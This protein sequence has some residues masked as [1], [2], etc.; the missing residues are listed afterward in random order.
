MKITPEEIRAFLSDLH[1]FHSMMDRDVLFTAEK[2]KIRICRKGEVITQIGTPANRIYLIK[3]G[4]ITLSRLGAN[5]EKV[6][7]GKLDS[8]EF[9]GLETW[10]INQQTQTEAVASSDTTLLYLMVDDLDLAA[11]RSP[12]LQS[13]LNMMLQS[14]NALVEMRLS[15]R[16]EDE[17]VFWTSRKHPIFLWVKL[18]IPVIIGA[19]VISAYFYLLLNAIG[20]LLLL[21]IA[22]GIALFVILLLCV[23]IFIDWGDDFFLITDRRVISRNRVLLLYENKQETPM[24]AI[25]SVGKKIDN[26]IGARIGYG[27]V[28]VRTFTG[29]LVLEKI[30]H[31]DQVA[32]FLE[33]IRSRKAVAHYELERKEKLLEMRRR[34]GMIDEN[35]SSDQ[36]NNPP[37]PPEPEPELNVGETIGYLFNQLFSLRIATARQIVYRKHWFILMRRTFIPGAIFTGVIAYWTILAVRQGILYQ[38]GYPPFVNFLVLLTT[39]FSIS[40]WTYEYFDWRNDRFIVDGRQIVD[41]DQKP[42]GKEHRRAAPLNAIQSVEYKRLGLIGIILNFGTVYIRVGDTEFTFD[43][44]ANPAMIQQEI[45]EFLTSAKEQERQRE[46]RRERERVLDWIEIYHTVV[47]GRDEQDGEID[48]E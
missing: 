31:P 17:Y 36:I 18:F 19:I 46:I 43:Q 22:T 21:N 35:Q 37:S 4:G 9:F 16:H 38:P 28:I 6:P 24:D 34:L 5:N 41:I 7:F 48:E 15:W 25:L 12:Y 40:W 29:T 13:F 44:V 42:L 1:P 10:G 20:S 2:M 3:E 8:G 33:D 32:S 26:F 30:P 45:S 23:Y 39:F 14:Y 27:D 47:N 11:E